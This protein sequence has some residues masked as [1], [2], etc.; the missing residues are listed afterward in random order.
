MGFAIAG[1]TTFLYGTLI[2]WVV[3]WMIHQR[4]AG[5]LYRS[6]SNH[7]LKQY[8][9]SD[10]VSER[11]RDAGKDSSLF[12]FLPAITVAFLIWCL[13]AYL[14]GASVAVL[15]M[16]VVEAAVIGW[17]HD[18]LHGQFHLKDSWTLRYDC[19]KQLRVWHWYHHRN[20]K[21]NLGIVWF[22]WDRVFRTFRG[23]L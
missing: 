10:L 15:V 13:G 21:R 11:Y 6:H 23:K 1:I 3:H 5:P 12:V 7:H 22:G 4:W 8:P 17:L 16:M 2:G 9:P 18:Y 19:L 14:L 20:M